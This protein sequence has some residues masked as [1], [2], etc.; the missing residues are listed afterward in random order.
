MTHSNSYHRYNSRS[1]QKRNS[2]NLSSKICVS[3]ISNNTK[4]K[5]LKERFNRYGPIKKISIKE[6]N[7]LMFRVKVLNL[8]ILININF[9]QQN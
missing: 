2:K 5:E 9:E 4:D 7:F 8:H 3:N 6:G 1:S